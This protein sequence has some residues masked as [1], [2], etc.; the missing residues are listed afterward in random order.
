M[1]PEPRRQRIRKT[2]ARRAYEGVIGLAADNEIT[3]GARIVALHR[4]CAVAEACIKELDCLAAAEGE[5][6]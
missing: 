5:Q 6:G 3:V 4:I 1:T 2:P